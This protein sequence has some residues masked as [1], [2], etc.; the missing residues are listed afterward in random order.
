M[1]RTWQYCILAASLALSAHVQAEDL[2]MSKPLRIVSATTDRSSVPVF[3]RITISVDLEATYDNPFDSSQIRLDAAVSSEN[4]ATWSVPGFICRPYSRAI[5]D[6]KETVSPSGPAAWQVRLSFPKPGKYAVVLS[7]TDKSKKIE[8]AP[9]SVEVTPGDTPGMIRRHPQDHRYFVTDRGKSFFLIGANICWGGPG[10]TYSYDQWLPK[11]AAAGCNYSRLWLAPDWTTFGTNTTPAG[12]NGID[13][14]NAWRLDYV[15]E[16]AGRLGI[17]LMLCIDSFNILR[18]AKR[19]YGSWETQVFCKQNGGPLGQPTEYF[20]DPA[21]LAAYRDRLRYLVARYG[22]DPTVFAWEFWN[23]VDLVDDYDSTAIAKWH[24]EMARY[25]HSIDP[26]KHL[27]STSFARSRGDDAVDTLPELDFVQTHRYGARDLVTQ[28]DTDR[29][30]KK[31]AQDRPHFHGEFGVHY[32]DATAKTDPT[33]IHIHDG[34]YASVGQTQAGTPMSWWWDSYIEPMNIYP[35]Y[36]SFRRWIDGF[37]FVAQHPKRITA[38]I[39][40][41]KSSENVGLLVSEDAQ[42]EPAPCNQPR[43]VKVS[44]SGEVECIGP[45]AALQHGVGNHPDCHNPVTFELDV[46]KKTDF[47]VEVHG[48]SGF[49]GAALRITLDGKVVLDEKFADNPGSDD[50]MHQFDREYRIRLPKGK[51]TVKVENTGQDWF[52]AAYRIPWATGLTPLRALGLQ[53]DTMGLVWVNHKDSG[54]NAT[55]KPS[56]VNGASLRLHGWRPGKWTVE[57]WDTVKGAVIDSKPI[58]VAD[59]GIMTIDLPPISWDAAYRIRQAS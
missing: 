55:A 31:A 48:V 45:L 15:L 2:G 58:E 13:L 7:A 23:E 39:V 30:S 53:G 22:W 36:A 8:A 41:G 25:L 34:L 33:G 50:T 51:H 56:P 27:I 4:G 16:Q 14:G 3:S 19:E 17:R 29:S 46:P 37:D 43:T 52:Y 6:G 47:A 38:S 26:W 32:L 18:S 11:Y 20:T 40:G 59:D 57:S 44:R 1:L 12:Y 35:I 24:K 54:W 28:F 49:G 9:I 10:G 5:Q 21:M 42:W